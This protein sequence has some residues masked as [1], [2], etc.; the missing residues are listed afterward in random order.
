M[1]KSRLVFSYPILR[2][3]L[4]PSNG[5]FDQQRAAKHKRSEPSGPTEVHLVLSM[6]S[7]GTLKPA[8]LSPNLLLWPLIPFFLIVT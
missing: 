7:R 4:I 6:G 8:D 1:S 3:K 5:A 2:Q